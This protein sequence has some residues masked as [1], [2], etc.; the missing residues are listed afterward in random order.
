MSKFERSLIEK[1]WRRV[2]GTIVLE[3]P[4]VR[5]LDPYPEVGVVIKE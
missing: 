1:Y 5:L 4:M 2:G 3:L